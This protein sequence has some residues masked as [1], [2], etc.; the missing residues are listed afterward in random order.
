MFDTGYPLIYVFHHP[1]ALFRASL[2]SERQAALA[3]LF[4]RV[5]RSKQ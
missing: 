4:L 3:V 2:S 5:I 1:R